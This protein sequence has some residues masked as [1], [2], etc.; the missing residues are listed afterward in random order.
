MQAAGV[1]DV[2]NL[3]DAFA[4]FPDLENVI[5]KIDFVSDRMM[6]KVIK[7]EG[8]AGALL[9]TR[10]SK[11]LMDGA[12]GSRSAKGAWDPEHPYSPSHPPY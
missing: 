9:P 3:K 6:S 7:A 1:H 10:H 12:A 8:E 5:V 2:R 11:F 4:K